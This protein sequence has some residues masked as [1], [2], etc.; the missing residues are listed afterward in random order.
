[1]LDVNDNYISLLN[2][3]YKNHL[4]IFILP[5]IL[6]IL[7]FLTYNI[8]IYDTKSMNYIYNDGYYS[9]TIPIQD[10]DNV[11]N[12]NYVVIDNK[13]YDFVIDSI[14]Y[15]YQDAYQTLLIKVLNKEGQI[16][17]QVGTIIFNFNKEKIIKKIIHL[18]F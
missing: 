11:I 5:I 17:N 14:L 3:Y 18:L 1:M 6:L 7:L 8:E 10:S 16:N 4:S 9:I 2:L 12:S 15:D 13:K